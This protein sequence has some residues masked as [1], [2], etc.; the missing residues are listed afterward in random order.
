M[1]V[2]VIVMVIV[3]VLVAMI[4]LMFDWSSCLFMFVMFRLKLDVGQ[5]GGCQVWLSV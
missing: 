1:F 4:C 5:P 2:M 3:M